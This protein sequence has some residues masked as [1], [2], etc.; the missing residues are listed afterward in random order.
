LTLST[1]VQLAAVAAGLG[2]PLTCAVFPYRRHRPCNG[3]GHYRG[4]L[5]G[6]IRLCAGCAGTGRTLRLGA[7]VFN[8]LTRR[9][10]R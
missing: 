7:R 8:A 5:F 9:R 2:Y 10:D 6:G 4:G 1:L 3:R